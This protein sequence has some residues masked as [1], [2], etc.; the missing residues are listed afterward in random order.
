MK[1]FHPNKYSI[2]WFKIAEFIARGEKERA[3]GVYRLLAHSLD[4]QPV[5]F[6]LEADILLSSHDSRAYEKYEKSAL[7]YCSDGR[8]LQ[9]AAVYEHLSSL[10]MLKEKHKIH[11]ILLYILL[12]N[13]FSA[14]HHIQSLVLSLIE[15]KKWNMLIEYSVEIKK[16]S[17]ISEEIYGIFYEKILLVLANQKIDEEIC[18]RHMTLFLEALSEVYDQKYVEKIINVLQEIDQKW[19][20]K[21][22][23]LFSNVMQH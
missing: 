17:E 16:R 20:L 7:L 4:D 3:L 6:Q 14:L 18:K 11:L 1:Q 23:A 21:A 15:S 10:Q 8:L 5:I 22:V 19:Y 2:A 13:D 12:Q 9:A